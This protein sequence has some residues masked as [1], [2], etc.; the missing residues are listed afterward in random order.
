[1]FNIVKNEMSNLWLNVGSYMVSSGKSPHD[2]E[3]AGF[4]VVDSCPMHPMP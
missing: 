2:D 1:M 3:D 4:L